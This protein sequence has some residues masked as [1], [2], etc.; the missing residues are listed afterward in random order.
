MG[1]I[2]A[3]VVAVAWCCSLAAPSALRGTISD[4]DA[5]TVGGDLDRDFDGRLHALTVS[6]SAYVR[7]SLDRDVVLA[8]VLGGVDGLELE[9]LRSEF[10]GVAVSG[11]V[12]V[13]VVVVSSI[14]V[15]G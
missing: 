11:S 2:V 12:V 5:L 7:S 10:G 15:V 1:V 13:H 4:L 8:A 6:M 3:V 14:V 9:R